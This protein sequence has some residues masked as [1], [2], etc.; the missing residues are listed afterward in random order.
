MDEMETMLDKLDNVN[1]EMTNKD[2]DNK[3]LAK[4]MEEVKKNIKESED[5]MR[6]KIKD[7][8]NEQNKAIMEKLDITIKTFPKSAVTKR[9]L[10]K[11]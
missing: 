6:Q 3:R 5:Q 10:H 4:E 8:I 2:G 11:D 9:P 7:L 1:E